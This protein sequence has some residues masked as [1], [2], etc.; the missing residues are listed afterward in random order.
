MIIPGGEHTEIKI[1]L[2][3]LTCVF[4]SSYKAILVISIQEST[5]QNAVWLWLWNFKCTGGKCT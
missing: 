4:L 5:G 2:F 1:N 3:F